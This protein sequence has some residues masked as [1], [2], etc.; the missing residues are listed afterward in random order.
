MLNSVSVL[1]GGCS[2]SA[3]RD[4]LGWSA[5]LSGWR[6]WESVIWVLLLLLLNI[7][8]VLIFIYM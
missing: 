7:A 6:G 8:V 4:E 5:W 3:V 2:V 1:V